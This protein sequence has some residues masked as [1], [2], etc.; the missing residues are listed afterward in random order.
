MEYIEAIREIGLVFALP[1][2]NLY[3]ESGITQL[4]LSQFTIDGLHPNEEGYRRI[5]SMAI[6]NMISKGCG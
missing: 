2:L 1:V 3:A 6:K 5:G 4:T